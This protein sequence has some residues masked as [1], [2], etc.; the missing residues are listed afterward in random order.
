MRHL[1]LLVGLTFLAVGTGASVSTGATAAEKIIVGYAQGSGL[2]PFWIAHEGGYFKKNGL[3]VEFVATGSSTVTIASLVSGDLFLSAGGSAGGIAAAAAGAPITLIGRCGRPPFSLFASDPTL[4]SVSDLKGKVVG[5]GSGQSDNLVLRYILQRSGVKYS[6]LRIIYQAD[7]KGRYA[8]LLT[9]R[10]SA[11][12]ISPPY[13]LQAKKAGLNEIVDFNRSGS[14]LMFCGLWTKRSSVEKQTDT[15]ERLMKAFLQAVA[16][17]KQDKAYAL[18]V[19]NKYTRNTDSELAEYTYQRQVDLIPKKPYVEDE[20]LQP[21]IDSLV[22]TWPQL[23]GRR[24]SEFYDNRIVKRL[25]DSG[26]IDALYR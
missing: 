13:D 5:S 18:L 14:S 11:A 19:F 1:F 20:G 2:W 24:P 8:A 4:R 9:G 23:K 21:L 15:L 6:D 17:L 26:Y 25:D 22:D 3:N 16:R 12:V 10:V 7:Q